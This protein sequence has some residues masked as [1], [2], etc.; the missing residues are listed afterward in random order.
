VT[1][2]PFEPPRRGRHV[3]VLVEP[4]GKGLWRAQQYLL[5]LAPLLEAGGYDGDL[6]RAQ[7]AIVGTSNTGEGLA[8]RLRVLGAELLGARVGFLGPRQDIAAVLRSVDVLV[9][10]SSREA[11]QQEFTA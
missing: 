9:Q 6:G 1:F 4:R 3:R 2:T 10:A 5:R 11:I 7:L 8:R